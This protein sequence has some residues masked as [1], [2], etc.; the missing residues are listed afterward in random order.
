MGEQLDNNV[1]ALHPLPWA[2][3]TPYT[4]CNGE[5]APCTVVD[6]D[7][8]FVCECSAVDDDMGKSEALMIVTLVNRAGP[9]VCHNCGEPASCFGTYEDELRPVYSCDQCCGHDTEELLIV[10]NKDGTCEQI[11]GGADG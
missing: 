5:R 6:D 9:R 4:G 10:Y 1:I 7:G 2:V 11:E 8:C 3:C